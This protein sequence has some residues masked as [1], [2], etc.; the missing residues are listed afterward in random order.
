[1]FSSYGHSVH[2]SQPND[3]WRLL[4]VGGGLVTHRQVVTDY[5]VTGLVF[6]TVLN[7]S[8]ILDKLVVEPREDLHGFLF[9]ELSLSWFIVILDETLCHSQ[10]EA[11]NRFSCVWVRIYQ[12]MDRP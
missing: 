10:M 12:R 6:V 4:S 8:F 7:L 5:E 1:M 11:E 9:T 3:L 2:Y